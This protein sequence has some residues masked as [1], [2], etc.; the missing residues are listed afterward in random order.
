MRRLPQGRGIMGWQSSGRAAAVAAPL[1]P[2][3]L[4]PEPAAPTAHDLRREA[5]RLLAEADAIDGGIAAPEPEPP[6]LR[7]ESV[8]VAARMIGCSTGGLRRAADANLLGESYKL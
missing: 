6:P 3:D 1:M 7:F 4:Q 2:S 5:A 8:R